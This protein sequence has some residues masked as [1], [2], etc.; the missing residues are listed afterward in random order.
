MSAAPVDATHAPGAP[1]PALIVGAGP[2]GLA[3]AACLQRRGIEA[4]VLEAG[5]SLA[6]SWR[7]HYD[8]LRLHTVKQQSHMPGLPFARELPRYPSRADVVAYLE[9]YAARFAIAPRTGE[10]V[11]RVRAEAGA[12]AVETPRAT[13]RARAVVMAAGLN[14]LPSAE[15]LPEQEHF[16]GT[17]IHSR[18]YRNADR[19]AGQ[20]VLVVGGGN[21]GAEIALDL[22]EHGARPTLALR[23]PV[24]V[25][26]RDF[27]GLP[28]QL[29]AIRTRRLP[30]K[31]RD[32]IGRLVSRLAFGNLARYGL[33]RP[34]FGPL[35]SIERRRRIPII[36]VGTIAAIKRGDIAVKPAVTRFTESGAVFADD[37]RAEL[38]AV[39]L[40]TG[41]RPALGEI[42]DM[43]GVLDD[44]GVPRDWRGG[45][46]QPNLFFVGYT[47][48]A[49][50]L[51][52]Q[53]G[54]EAE[55]AAAAIATAG[56]LT[57][58]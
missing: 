50:G 35:T 8:R 2:A 34:A 40:A 54:I 53:I 24:N 3:S 11:N 52:R 37:T 1:L 9:T 58:T 29:T 14:R 43:P 49:T 57:R 32:A 6:H 42:L 20:R 47:Q 48:P 26:P 10:A 31:L 46:V 19:F 56:A 51:L 39:V 22:A 4:L 28:T 45:G 44:Q 7:H 15:G 27:L 23:S 21:T 16:R 12:F 55:A 25:V 13:Y 18:D 33:A 5:P 41:Y 38:D 36:D 17:V 30:I